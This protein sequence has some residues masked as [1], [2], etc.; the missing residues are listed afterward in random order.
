MRRL[1]LALALLAVAVAG[2]YALAG[3]REVVDR[4]RY[5]IR[6]AGIVRT[7]AHNY[8]L[9]PALLAAVIAVESRF[10]PH[11]RSRAGAIGLMQLLPDTAKG[12]AARTGGSKFSVADLDTPE[13]NVRYGSWYLRHLLDRYQGRPNTVELALAAYNAGSG[14]V[15]R[16][17]AASP[18]SVSVSIPSA[19]AET[20]AYVDR[21]RA[22][23]K[24]YRKLYAHQLGIA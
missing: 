18:G 24:I 1:L 9:D 15:D 21:V 14:N 5:P 23:E 13:I 2:W 22:Y 8:R 11:V 4:A 12:I 10:R 17:V 7:H 16:W 3:G 6:Y 20:R 19:F